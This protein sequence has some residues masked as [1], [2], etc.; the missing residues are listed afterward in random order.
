MR[1]TIAA[2][3]LITIVG[4]ALFLGGSD[5]PSCSEETVRV[6][7]DEAVLR[8]RDLECGTGPAARRGDELTVHYRGTLAD[9][10]EFD[11]SADGEPIRFALGAG[12]V[13]AGWEEGLEGMRAGGRRRLV[14]P[15]ELGY[16]ESGF[17]PSI[18][19]NATLIFEVELVAVSG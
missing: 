14:I 10:R 16:G 12:T 6:E 2:A 8:Y 5:P 3:A 19:P 1:L 4:A 15:P 13:I 17:P 9:G 11:S 7:V 18:P